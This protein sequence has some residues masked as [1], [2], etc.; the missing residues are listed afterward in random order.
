[1]AK[2]DRMVV[3]APSRS[4]LEFALQVHVPDP[5]QAFSIEL[6]GDVVRVGKAFVLGILPLARIA[7]GTGRTAQVTTVSFA[8][9]KRSGTDKAL[10]AF[11]QALDQK[12]PKRFRLLAE[13]T[14]TFADVAQAAAEKRGRR[15]KAP[16]GEVILRMECRLSG[17][18]TV[19]SDPIP[20]VLAADAV[21]SGDAG[22]EGEMWQLF[23]CHSHWWV[24][25][26]KGR[27]WYT[28]CHGSCPAGSACGC[29]TPRAPRCWGLKLCWC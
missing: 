8:E 7:V 17:S 23:N 22:P 20:C 18:R 14:M 5:G 13:G 19:I 2:S 21:P 28:V 1:M 12:T 4:D 29:G 24:D 6:P 3:G 25:A 11:D 26:G 16:V 27:R 10:A 15:R 9:K